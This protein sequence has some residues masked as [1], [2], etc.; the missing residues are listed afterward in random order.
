[1]RWRSKPDEPRPP[2]E[3]EPVPPKQSDSGSSR[4]AAGERYDGPLTYTT[5]PQI[6][7]PGY[8]A[9]DEVTA[10]KEGENTHSIKEP[11]VMLTWVD[12]APEDP[13]DGSGHFIISDM[14]KP[15]YS[16]LPP[17]LD[18]NLVPLAAIVQGTSKVT[19]S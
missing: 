1:M 4:P 14:E 18:E 17:H 19:P 11:H 10:H 2:E 5:D 16:H 9:L 15:Y 3:E 8:Y 13:N 6:G 12:E 7:R